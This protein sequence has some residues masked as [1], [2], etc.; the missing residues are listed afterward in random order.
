[1]TESR[2]AQAAAGERRYYLDWLRVISLCLLIVFH[3]AFVYG[4]RH[5]P[6]ISVHW[7]DWMAPWLLTLTPWR[8]SLVYLV[9][10]TAAGIMVLKL[11]WLAFVR[12]RFFRLVVPLAFTMLVIIPPQEWLSRMQSGQAPGELLSFWWRR[13]LPYPEPGGGL[14]FPDPLHVW[15]LPFLFAYCVGLALFQAAAPQAL[16]SLVA[17]PWPRW[18]MPAIVVAMGVHLAL[19]A[20]F[21]EPR[22]PRTYAL[23]NDLTAHVRWLPVFV[24][25][26]LVASR[27][28]FWQFLAEHRWSLTAGALGAVAL[29]L[30]VRFHFS[31][32]GQLDSPFAVQ[33]VGTLKGIYG[34]ATLFAI[35]GHARRLLTRDHAILRFM[36]EAIMPIYLLHYLGIVLAMLL[37]GP[38][39]LPF[40][41]EFGALLLGAF[42]PPLLLYQLVIRRSALLL[43]LCGMKGRSGSAPAGRQ[44]QVPDHA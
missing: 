35:A 39:L 28:Q 32:L 1:M 21:L 19:C 29:M 37:V 27:E 31:Q 8:M 44:V 12:D 34:A 9:S 16:R 10:G 24:L 23:H 20:A 36:R 11:P 3:V 43:T 25:G 22:F 6:V 7:G 4:P 15:F 38:W 42:L 41:P 26:V 14:H 13:A 18:I 2:S 17:R 33:A 40:A 30:G 5:W